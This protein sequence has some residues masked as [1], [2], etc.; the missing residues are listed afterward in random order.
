MDS[1]QE[2]DWCVMFVDAMRILRRSRTG[3]MVVPLNLDRSGFPRQFS[4]RSC[5]VIGGG[6]IVVVWM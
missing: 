4:E 3:L 1:L 6:R 5:R 2:Q